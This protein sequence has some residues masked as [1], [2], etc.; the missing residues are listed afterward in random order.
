[1]TRRSRGPLVAGLAAAV[2]LVAAGLFAP[3]E[4]RHSA[5]FGFRLTLDARRG[6]AVR[7]ALV[8]ANYPDFDRV[9][10]DLRAYDTTADYD[11]TLHVR[12]HPPGSRPGAADVRTVAIAVPGERI[13]HNKPAFGNPFVTV[14]FPP[15]ADSAG[16][17]YYVWVEPGPRN[18]DDILA[19]WSLK[20]YSAVS[21]REVLA[22]FLA[23][24]P[25]ARAPGLVRAGLLA[26]LLGFAAAVGWLVGALVGLA[27][28]APRPAVVGVA[29]RWPAGA[30]APP[31][32]GV[33]RREGAGL[34]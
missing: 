30:P 4:A 20:T 18:R 5:P 22:A 28:A 19:L 27:T 32:P 21:G 7:G 6:I 15:I 33:V 14:R 10:L 34:P 17:R 1:M 12:P 26:V 11:L 9:D 13:R 24:P 31:A 29:R 2:I 3:L 25:G 23:D 8:T 16:K